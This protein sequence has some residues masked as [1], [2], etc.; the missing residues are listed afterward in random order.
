MS[1]TPNS[2]PKAESEEIILSD[3]SPKEELSSETLSA[4]SQED[5]SSPSAPEEMTDI[6]ALTAEAEPT[7]QAA[8]SVDIS[9][10]KKKKF[11][12]SLIIVLLVFVALVVAGAFFAP[13]IFPSL[14]EG[15]SIGTPAFQFEE[16]VTVGDISLSG[17]TEEAALEKLQALV[18]QEKTSDTYLVSVLYEDKK[19]EITAADI[20]FASNAESV[21][22]EA[23]AY[24]EQLHAYQQDPENASAPTGSGSFS[25]KITKDLSPVRTKLLD[26]AKNINKAP[27]EPTVLDFN[28]ETLSFE[29]EDGIKGIAVD[30]EALFNEVAAVLNTIKKGTVYVPVEEVGFSETAQDLKERMKLL[31]TYTTY[32]DNT[33]NAE[34]NMGLALS[35]CNNSIIP[36]GST[37]SF[38]GA[39]G[40]SM[41]EG[42]GFLPAGAWRGGKLVQENGGGICQSAT[43]IYGAA[44]R[45]GMEIVERYCHLQPSSYCPVGLD[46]TVDY[47]WLD[48]RVK[49]TTDYPM[50]MVATMIGKELTVS[51]YGYQS[52]DYAYIEPYGQYG[53][54]IEMPS[55]IY[56]EDPSLSPGQ[57]ERT[58]L[59]YSGCTAT[60]SRVYYDADGNVLRTEALPS[61]TYSAVAPEY[62]IGP[63]TDT[64]LI[65]PNSSSGT[66][67][68]TEP[69]PSPS[70]EIDATPTPTPEA[71]PAPEP[72][73]APTPTP[74]P[75]PAPTP[76]PT[77]EATPTPTPGA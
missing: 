64:S 26:F 21:L 27:V 66:V 75:T 24:S 51:I 42:T 36:A 19:L 38:H 35:R 77:P 39:V 12:S 7:A 46:A 71:T 73:P 16:G 41:S 60:A 30:E 76:T 68:T 33:A 43:T 59:G 55:A 14:K 58:K 11:P 52:P 15:L 48:L 31:G 63:N 37:F 2:T 57:Y 5:V 8:P 61:S 65:T 40:D 20:I 10:A 34:H 69:T 56:K 32:A 67:A 23:K 74:T 50:Y 6:S 44:L 28:F 9:S 1:N 49:N 18:E 22:Q 62:K 45:A 29:F 13:R 54:Y 25:V 47:P 17:L 4:Q 72:T 70:P 3:P 53:S